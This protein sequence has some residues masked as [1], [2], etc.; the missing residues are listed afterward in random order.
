MRITFV[1]D[2]MESGGAERVI[3]T[4]ANSF[5]S[6][7]HEVS[8]IMLAKRANGSFYELDKKINLLKLIEN[9]EPGFF[10]KG[11]LLKKKIIETKPD[12]VVSFLSYV[13]IYTW[14]ALRNTKIPYIVSERN[15]PNSRGKL[16]QLLLNRSYKKAKGRVFQTTDAKEWYEK[17]GI[18]NGIVIFNPVNLTYLPVELGVTKKQ[19]LYVGRYNEQKNCKLLIDAFEKFY[20]NH[21][22]FSLKMYGDG[23]LKDE[24]LSY[25]ESKKLSNVIS[26]NPS[27]KTW[28]KDEYNSAMFVITS[29]FEGMPNV[30][31]E[32]LCLG[33]PSISTDCPIGGPKELGR[34]FPEQLSLC[35]VRDLESI[36]KAMGKAITVERVKASIPDE[37]DRLYISKKWL[38]Y[39]ESSIK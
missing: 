6:L 9:D 25:I 21:R 14:F 20:G 12:V 17:R 38:N 18:K 8:I 16:K 3:A 7:N 1:C 4:L 27:S 32:A 37:L 24:L 10:K 22:D 13:C 35:P 5:V 33:I 19:V 15:N 26:L 29:D 39:I 23:N 30:L 36:V 31:A 28:Q 11:H 34:L 2:T